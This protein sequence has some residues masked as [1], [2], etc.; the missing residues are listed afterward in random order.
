M[1]KNEKEIHKK[2]SI[3]F[4][5]LEECAPEGQHAGIFDFSEFELI[6]ENDTH[7]FAN[8]KWKFTK[9]LNIPW[10]GALITER[11]ERGQWLVQ[12][13]NRNYTDICP[14]LHRPTEPV[15]DIF[16]HVAGCPMP[17]GVSN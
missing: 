3:Y 15:Y 4:T 7:T 8:G 1:L 12:A 10:P 9:P 2:N 13:F 17:A 14:T 16:K 5:V 11:Y 6:P